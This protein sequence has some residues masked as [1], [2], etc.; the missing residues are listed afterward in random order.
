MGWFRRKSND[1]LPARCEA[2]LREGPPAHMEN[3]V[4]ESLTE[5]IIAHGARSEPL[6][7][8]LR[9]VGGIVLMES[10]S[11]VTYEDD[12]IRAYMQKGV[13][14]VREVLERPDK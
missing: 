7:D 1:D 3:Y 13:D 10:S 11:Y 4:P 8:E 5:I 6:D 12:E 9:E 2:Y 14:L